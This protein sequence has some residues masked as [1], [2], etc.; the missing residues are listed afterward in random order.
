MLLMMPPPSSH[1]IRSTDDARLIER[2]RSGDSAAYESLVREAGPRMLSVAR[3]FLANEQDAQEAVQ[4]AQEAVQDAF[5]SAFKAL[6]SFEGTS[7]LTTW[8]HRITVNAAL[9]KRRSKSRRPERFL[10]DLLPKYKD[11]G[12]RLHPRE[13]WAPMSESDLE[14]AETRE[15]IHR[16]VDEL[17]EDYATI[18]LLRDIEGM[19]TAATA[20]H[21]GISEPAVKTRLHRARQALRTL[22]E[23]ALPKEQQ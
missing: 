21:L 3:R 1:S 14:R 4:D 15:L 8:I 2:L 16:L 20:Q 6:P 5:L 11:D 9:M 17:P 19:D 13:P 18:V 12:H 23:E 22:L 10:D 7:K